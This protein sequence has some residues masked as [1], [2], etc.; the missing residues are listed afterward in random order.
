MLNHRHSLLPEQREERLRG[1]RGV[2]HAPRAAGGEQ[3]RPTG[4]ALRGTGHWRQGAPTRA[5][6]GAPRGRRHRPRRHVAL[7]GGAVRSTLHLDRQVLWDLQCRR[8]V[9]M[10]WVTRWPTG[11][12][13]KPQ[14][15]T[16]LTSRKPQIT[17]TDVCRQNCAFCR[18]YVRNAPSPST[19][20]PSTVLRYAS[21][22]ALPG[23]I[24]GSALSSGVVGF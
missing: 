6:C 20:R 22:T 16:R 14:V 18:K 7:D 21:P 24:V 10:Q 8:E 5:D 11:E 1:G 3:H 15:A 4:R 2:A 17:S 12:R 9:R 13:K 23:N 19:R